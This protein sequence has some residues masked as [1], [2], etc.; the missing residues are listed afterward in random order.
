MNHRSRALLFILLPLALSPHGFLFSSLFSPSNMLTTWLI[1]HLRFAYGTAMKRGSS[2]HAIL[3]EKMFPL[4]L[5]SLTG[6]FSCSGSGKPHNNRSSKA[7]GR[8]WHLSAIT[9]EPPFPCHR[10]DQPVSCV[11]DPLCV[12]T[13]LNICPLL[14]TPH[15]NRGIPL[16]IDLGSVSC[17]NQQL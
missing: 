17:R 11:H 6:G 1:T 2:K 8:L 5:V 3:F 15:T 12:A 10:P 9:V 13:S 4:L 16:G 14:P 7:V